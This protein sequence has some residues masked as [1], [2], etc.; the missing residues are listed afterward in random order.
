MLHRLCGS[1]SIPF[2]FHSCNVLPRWNTYCVCCGTEALLNP[3][4]SIH[5]LRRDC[6]VSNPV[7]SPRFFEPQCQLQSSEPPSPLVYFLLIS[8]H[9]TAAGNSTP[10]L[11]HSSLTVSK[12]VPG[13][14]PGF[15][16]RLARPT[17]TPFTPSK[18]SSLLLT[19]I[20][21]RLLARI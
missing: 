11:L 16:L 21:P 17:Y 7:C 8:T 20:T 3:T 19:V 2:E 6:R 1:P 18:S 5:R 10:H 15:S 14:S 9:F 12:A 13:L 4:P